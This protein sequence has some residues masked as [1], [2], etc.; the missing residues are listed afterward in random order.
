MSGGADQNRSGGSGTIEAR[1]AKRENIARQEAAPADCAASFLFRIWLTAVSVSAGTRKGVFVGLR[2]QDV[3]D[4]CDL[5]RERMLLA[6]EAVAFPRDPK[7]G[8]FELLD[9]RRQIQNLSYLQ[10]IDIP[11]NLENVGSF[12][13]SGGVSSRIRFHGQSF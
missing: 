4:L 1:L 8:L 10:L 13:S 12:R 6:A 9:C 2:L 11:E 7:S 5:A 3:V